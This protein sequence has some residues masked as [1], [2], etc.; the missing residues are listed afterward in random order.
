MSRPLLKIIFTT[1]YEVFGNGSGDLNC[2]VLEPT[3]QMVACLEEVGAR[4]CVFLDLAEYWAFTESFERGHLEEDWAG[5]MKS[6]LQALLG[7]GHDVQLHLHPQW[8]DYRKTDSGWSL[9]YDMWRI[10]KL[11][12]RDDQ[13]PER[14]LEKL[15]ARAKND[16]EDLFQAVKASY[17]CEVFRAGA[18]SIQPEEKVLRALSVNGFKLDSTAVPGLHF[19][20][21]LTFY[22]F[23]KAPQAALPYPI[24]DN[25]NR[26]VKEGPLLE[27]P[28]FSAPLTLP[29]RLY[30]Q[31]LKKSRGIPFKPDACR[32]EAIASQKQ[33]IVTKVLRVLTQSQQM[34]TFGDA[35]ACE[36]MIYF[37]RQARKRAVRLKL[38]TMPVVAISHPKTFANAKE[39]RRFLD[40][41]KQ[42]EDVE[43]SNYQDILNG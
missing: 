39:F 41:A 11:A 43:F 26:P 20:D 16:M 25:V 23:R 18:W 37:V 35:T 7:R 28:I 30:F 8:L 29:K 13:Y 17:R 1:D 5:Q 31:Y 19:S 36:E 4:L 14:G 2:C 40:W 21:G 9:N 42:E 22:D 15:F 10:G 33:S 12:Y 3:A 38:T 24:R 6:Q 27:Q 34:F 32:G